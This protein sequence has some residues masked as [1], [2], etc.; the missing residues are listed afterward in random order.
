MIIIF[1]LKDIMK[2]VLIGSGNVMTHL[3]RR[4]VE[5]GHEVIQIYS[6]NI[7]HARQLCESLSCGA[8][9]TD[10][11][12]D[13][14]N[15]A[16]VYIISVS[17]SVLPEV[18]AQL[19]PHRKG[20]FV[21]T[22]GS[23]PL[24]IFDGYAERY[25]ILY[26]LQTFSRQRPIEH[27]EE[28]PFFIEGSDEKTLDDI[29]RIARSLTSAQVIPMDS[30]RRKYLHLAAVFACNFANH[31]YA[32]AGEILSKADID[33]HV[34]NALI[35]ETARKAKD[36]DPKD[37]QTGPAARKD[38]NVME[39]HLDMLKENPRLR[40]LYRLLSESIMTKVK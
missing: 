1:F 8:T 37:V 7:D 3:G 15:E 19:C 11:I 33:F 26:P 38:Y 5:C 10:Y 25:G 12:R 13:V 27:F 4:I 22:S 34:M 40:V 28:I 14:V 17:D 9:A 24:S 39:R 36:A 2:T 31:C 35:E 20:L 32:L 30:E 6:R 21:H 23:I 29:S 18:A 16:D